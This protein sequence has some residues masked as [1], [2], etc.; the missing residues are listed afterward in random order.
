MVAITRIFLVLRLELMIDAAVFD[1]TV[2]MLNAPMAPLNLLKMAR[3]LLKMASPGRA[4]LAASVA[5][6]GKSIPHDERLL[7]FLGFFFFVIRF[8]TL[9]TSARST[10]IEGLT[11]VRARAA[12]G[13]LVM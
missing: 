5:N 2:C 3:Y 9:A 8:S 4:R 6:A 11:I 7:R 1:R 13:P 10:S 12:P